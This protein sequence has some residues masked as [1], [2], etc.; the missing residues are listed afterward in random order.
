MLE[1]ANLLL[2]SGYEA[3][4]LR[5]GLII[6]QEFGVIV[7]E[8]TIPLDDVAGDHNPPGR[9]RADRTSARLVELTTG[10]LVVALLTVFVLFAGRRRRKA[11]VRHGH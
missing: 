9:F 6:Q 10:G 1:A 3:E 7:Q 4:A 8:Q 2:H 11:V 5:V